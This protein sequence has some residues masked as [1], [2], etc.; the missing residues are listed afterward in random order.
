MSQGANTD[1]EL[2]ADRGR[3]VHSCCEIL[4]RPSGIIAISPIWSLSAFS[5]M[6]DT[7][8]WSA[9]TSTKRRWETSWMPLV[10]RLSL[11]YPGNFL[12]NS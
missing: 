1:A 11:V 5:L 8:G 3:G 6:A 10:Q 2:R 7:I 12:L 9:A 4:T